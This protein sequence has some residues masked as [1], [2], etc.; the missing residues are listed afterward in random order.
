MDCDRK[1][2]K[3]EPRLGQKLVMSSGGICK[4]SLL[5]RSRIGAFFRFV[6]SYGIVINGAFGNKKVPC[7]CNISTKTPAL[8]F[9]LH[10]SHAF[11]FTLCNAILIFSLSV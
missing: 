9:F 3:F 6:L 7:M 1:S 11:L 4:Y 10:A 8:S 5:I 2:L